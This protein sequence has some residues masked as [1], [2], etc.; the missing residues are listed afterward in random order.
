MEEQTTYNLVEKD[1]G[2]AAQVC[3]GCWRHV[4]GHCYGVDKEPRLYFCSPDCV[5]RWIWRK[6]H[7]KAAKVTVGL[8]ARVLKALDEETWANSFKVFVGIK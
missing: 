3:G 6:T 5:D 8:R 2:S 7:P 1:A 4:E